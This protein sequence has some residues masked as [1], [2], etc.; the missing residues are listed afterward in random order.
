MRSWCLCLPSFFDLNWHCQTKRVLCGSIPLLIP[1][2]SGPHFGLFFLFGGRNNNITH[3]IDVRGL[4]RL[5]YYFTVWCPLGVVLLP[6]G[7]FSLIFWFTVFVPVSS[8]HFLSF[9][10]FGIFSFFHTYTRTGFY[11]F[12]LDVSSSLTRATANVK[13]LFF[14]F[15]SDFVCLLRNKMICAS[16][17]FETLILQTE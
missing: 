14:C 12:I 8:S 16:T 9:S 2:M 11:V 13:N 6:F 5:F 4:R 3:I 17:A 1:V 15:F 7:H 10:Y